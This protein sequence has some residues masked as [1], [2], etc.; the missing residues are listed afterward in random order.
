MGKKIDLVGQKFNRLTVIHPI[1]NDRK[2]S[3]WL[4]QCDCGNTT[5]ATTTNLRKNRHKSCGCLR[6]GTDS[7]NYKEKVYK[8]GYV[9][10]W[11]PD[12]PRSYQNRVREHILVME[13]HLGR[14]LT[15]DEQIHHINGIRDDNR[16]KNLELWSKSQPSGTR[17]EDK[18]KWAKQILNQYAPWVIK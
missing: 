3:Y 4:C 16:I 8:N 14:Y 9:F 12:H 13:K 2:N 10:V 1:E 15:D 5:E 6:G 11:S 18:V 17:V 7:W